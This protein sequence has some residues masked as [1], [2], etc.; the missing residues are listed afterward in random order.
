MFPKMNVPKNECS[1]KS[2]FPMYGNMCT[3]NKRSREMSFNY[4]YIGHLWIYRYECS[5]R[6]LPSV[7]YLWLYIETIVHKRSLQLSFNSHALLCVCSCAEMYGSCETRRQRYG[8]LLQ[9]PTAYLREYT[10]VL[11][12]HHAP[13]CMCSFAEM[14]GSL[15]THRQKYR[16][17]LQE[18]TAHLREYTAVLQIPYALLCMCSFAGF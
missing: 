1:L 8:A 9:E 17:L 14:S 6:G 15:E 16:A 10:A 12:M 2:M 7:P 4:G 13:L 5:L 11:Q 3:Q 18:Y